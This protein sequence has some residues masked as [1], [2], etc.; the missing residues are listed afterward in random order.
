MFY[1]YTVYSLCCLA[2]VVAGVIEQRNHYRNLNTIPH[3]VLVN[4]IRGKSSI[5]RL[6]A[7]ALRGGTR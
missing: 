6:C 1:L 3:R 5:T 7:G 2:L 4:G